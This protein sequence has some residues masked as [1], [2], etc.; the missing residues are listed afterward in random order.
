LLEGDGAWESVALGAAGRIGFPDA[1][2]GCGAVGA[3][4]A[5]HGI[6]EHIETVPGDKEGVALGAIGVFAIARAAG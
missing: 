3:G 4:V 2:D 5:F 6:F 1:G